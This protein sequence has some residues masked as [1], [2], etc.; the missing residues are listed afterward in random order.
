MITSLFCQSAH[1]P[2]TTLKQAVIVSSQQSMKQIDMANVAFCLQSMLVQFRCCKEYATCHRRRHLRHLRARSPASNV[3]IFEYEYLQT[4]TH[5]HSPGRRGDMRAKVQHA[6]GESPHTILSKYCVDVEMCR[7]RTRLSFCAALHN[8]PNRCIILPSSSMVHGANMFLSLDLV[9]RY[10][11]PLAPRRAQQGNVGSN[12][13]GKAVRNAA[14]ISAGPS[15]RHA[16]QR[17]ASQCHVPSPGV[18]PCLLPI[19]KE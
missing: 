10:E 18:L 15:G 17:A 14:R 16:S 9:R 5:T 2:V 8:S 3:N 13:S 1:L 19:L 11:F 12:M 4:H 6:M 7:T